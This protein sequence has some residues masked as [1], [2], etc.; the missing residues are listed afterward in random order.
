MKHQLEKELNK[1]WTGELASVLVFW[2]CYFLWTKNHTIHVLYP[3]LT[4]C[5]ILIQG[6]AYWL[7]CLTRLIRKKNSFRYAGKIFRVLKYADAILLIAYIPILLMSPI[8]SL[9]YYLV[10]IFLILF[11]FVE[12]INY[13]LYRLSY[14]KLSILLLQIRSNSLR[15][16]KLAKEIE[17]RDR[18]K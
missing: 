8:V 12:Y 10:G 4:L 2:L 1:L 5:L 7:I 9:Q 14:K 6:S 18:I 16:S 13:F 15:K 17:N 11:S 3:L